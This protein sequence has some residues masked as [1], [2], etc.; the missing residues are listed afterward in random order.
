MP[1]PFPG[2]AA[3]GF[4]ARTQSRRRRRGALRP[5]PG[6]RGKF[7]GDRAPPH[8]GPAARSAEPG[9]AARPPEPA[10]LAQRRS[11]WRRRVDFA[12]HINFPSS[13]QPAPPRPSAPALRSQARCAH[14]GV[15]GRRPTVGHLPVRTPPSSRAPPAPRLRACQL[16]RGPAQPRQESPK[17]RRDKPLKRPGRLY[18]IMG[19]SR[20]GAGR[21]RRERQKS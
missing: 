18:R 4:V 1:G 8:P 15:Q 21:A 13:R 7:G 19:S 5:W 3:G 20:L 17:R 2:R 12:V 14:P 16:L 10:G 9:L 11:P 6:A